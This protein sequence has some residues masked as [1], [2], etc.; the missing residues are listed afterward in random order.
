MYPTR[1]NSGG[2]LITAGSLHSHAVKAI[3]VEKCDWYETVKSL[4][5]LGAVDSTSVVRTFGP[6]RCI[7]PSMTK[8]V[9]ALSS[10]ATL[11]CNKAQPAA[12][13]SRVD[14]AVIG[15]SIKVAG[16]DDV[17]EFWKLLCEGQSQHKQVPS[18]RMNFQTI[19]R[20]HDSERKWF[21]NFV[22]DV[23]AFDQKFFKKSARE[24]AS[25]DPQ[26]RHML[27]AGYQALEQSGYFNRPDESR[28]KNVSCYIG[29]CAADYENNM[30]CHEPNAFTAT[31]NLKGFIAGKLSHHFGWTGPAMCIDTACSSSLVALDLACKSILS[32]ECNTARKFLFPFPEP[33]NHPH[34]PQKGEL[35]ND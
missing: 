16:A 13:T 10:S 18:E 19:W 15:M 26:Q 9:D 7:P 8:I 21:G 20:T 3:L 35:F 14:V 33:W 24:A 30:A 23:D 34:P 32:G 27:Q 1:A 5:S 6:E 4:Y 29:V 17:A 22:N 2:H 31:G 11:V 25:M 28:D 12:E